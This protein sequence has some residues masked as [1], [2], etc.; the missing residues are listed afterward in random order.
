[1]LRLVDE[2]GDVLLELSREDIME[3][4]TRYYERTDT[5]GDVISVFENQLAKFA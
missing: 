4:V 1:M 3:H 2:D 5:C